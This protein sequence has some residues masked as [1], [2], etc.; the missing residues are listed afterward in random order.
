MYKV[1]LP[2]MNFNN[3]HLNTANTQL[4]TVIQLNLQISN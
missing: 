4:K 2:N 1:V 3:T